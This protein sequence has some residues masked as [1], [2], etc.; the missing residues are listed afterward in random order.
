M[1]CRYEMDHLLKMKETLPYSIDLPN[2]L[3][4]PLF[5]LTDPIPCVNL[6]STP[7]LPS[8]LTPIEV[9]RN[10]F[11]KPYLM[12]AI[13]DLNT[14]SGDSGV[15][16]HF[17]STNLSIYYICPHYC[18]HEYSDESLSTYRKYRAVSILSLSPSLFTDCPLIHTPLFRINRKQSIALASL[19]SMS[20]QANF[21]AA[22]AYKH[23]LSVE[24]LQ[25]RLLY[26]S[27]L[28]SLRQEIHPQ[29]WLVV[30]YSL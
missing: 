11:K 21:A 16:L 26:H 4:T 20:D 5:P 25:N 18:P 1:K 13:M 2:H 27:I 19:D 3:F 28:Q 23:S 8:A 24:N 15:L 10:E 14:L 29:R 9:V 30:F 12:Q 7:L 17:T 6:G 22:L